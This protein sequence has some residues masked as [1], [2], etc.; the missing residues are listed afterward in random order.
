M[1]SFPKNMKMQP[2]EWVMPYLM[3]FLTTN[4]NPFHADTQ[5]LLLVKAT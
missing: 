5:K 3:A 1:K 4:K 2:T